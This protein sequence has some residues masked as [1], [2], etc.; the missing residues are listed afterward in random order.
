MGDIARALIY[1]GIT[2]LGPRA[3]TIK[4]FRELT[5]EGLARQQ[6][7][8]DIDTMDRLENL[9][10]T[11]DAPRSMRDPK[12]P[13]RRKGMI[14]QPHV[15]PLSAFVARLRQRSSLE[16]PDF[17]PLDGAPTLESCSFLKSPDR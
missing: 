4:H 9:P 8:G 2:L 17:D 3:C 11:D 5:D 7:R 10:P 12:V 13:E 15:S 1:G 16:V 14:D 6:Q